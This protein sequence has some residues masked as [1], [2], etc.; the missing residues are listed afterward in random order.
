MLAGIIS[1]VI[2]T[3]AASSVLLYYLLHRD[4]T[5]RVDDS[6]ERSVREYAQRVKS[7]NSPLSGLPYEDAEAF[8]YEAMQATLPSEHEGM[9]ATIDRTV[10]W[11]AP[12]N[13]DVRLESDKEFMAWAVAA[14]IS[15]ASVLRSV[16][17]A[18]TTY[19]AVILP[20]SIADDPG[21]ARFILAFDMGKQAGQLKATFVPYIWAAAGSLVVAAVISWFL[22]GRLLRPLR[23]LRNTAQSITDED[24][25]QRIEVR[26]KGELAELTYTFNAML[27]R[28][29]DAVDSQKQLLDDVGHELRTPLTIVR[30]HLEVLDPSDVHDVEATRTLAIDELDRMSALVSDLLL[31][32]KKDRADFV[33]LEPTVLDYLA[34][35]IFAKAQQLGARQWQLEADSHASVLADPARLTQA[36][37]QLCENAVKYSPSDATITLRTGHSGSRALRFPIPGLV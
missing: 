25:S 9:V 31:L 11:K 21:D 34:E 28:V 5:S 18:T 30:G 10:R 1:M 22:T 15:G 13:V 35:T 2:V 27:D 23:A 4:M 37:L 14:D 3:M 33:S 19:R 7:P 36:V 6:L 16:E 20:A 32:A 8:L 24:L 26:A 17:T 29:E 12:Q